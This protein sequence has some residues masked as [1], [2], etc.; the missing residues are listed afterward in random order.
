MARLYR[1]AAGAL[2]RD[3][4]GPGARPRFADCVINGT[5]DH[6]HVPTSL[7]LLEAGYDMLLEKPFATSEEEMWALVQAAR[8]AAAAR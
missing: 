8:A 6:Q 4:R 5:M 3:G 1:L 2:L 7:P